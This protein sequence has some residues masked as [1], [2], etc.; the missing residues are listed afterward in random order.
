[1]EFRLTYIYIFWLNMASNW[2]PPSELK[3]GTGSDCLSP[4][5]K[6]KTDVGLMFH[7]S[8]TVL[9][10]NSSDNFN[11]IGQPYTETVLGIKA[12]VCE[13]RILVVQCVQ[14]PFTDSS[15]HFMMTYEPNTLA[16]KKE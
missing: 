11:T 8:Q 14:M 6:A 4:F 9:S 7:V 16:G 12:R 15:V 10:L 2:F 13:R 3:F 5:R 1:M